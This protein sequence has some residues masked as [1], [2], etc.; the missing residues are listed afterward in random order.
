MADNNQSQ[1]GFDRS[2]EEWIK[3]QREREKKRQKR[4]A[5]R[6]GDD[7][8]DVNINSL[9]DIMVIMLVF[10]LKSYGEEP[11]QAVGDDLKVPSSTSQLEPADTMTIT[12]RRTSIQ[13]NDSTIVDLQDGEVDPSQLAGD[14][15]LRIERLLEELNEAVDQERSEAEITGEEY[16]PEATVI[17]DQTTRHRLILKVLYTATEAELTQFRFAV[18][19]TTGESVGGVEQAEAEI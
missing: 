12:I 15:E 1:G 17:A 6:G 19:Q 9:M 5:R 8:T 3:A 18:I 13:V 14:G 10:L 4:A 16:E 7:D 2:E 11:I